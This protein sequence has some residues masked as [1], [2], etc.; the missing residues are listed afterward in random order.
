MYL[1]KNDLENAERYIKRSI[2]VFEIT[3]GKD[4]PLVA[5]AQGVHGNV[6]WR[7]GDREGSRDAFM[8][9]YEIEATRDGC[10]SV[11]TLM[12]LNQKI[13]DTYLRPLTSSATGKDLPP[14]PMVKLI[15]FAVV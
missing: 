1:D 5:S 9:S 2:S 14:P 6:L 11:M 8:I 3:C 13:M 7:K 12:E 4:S 10:V 15:F